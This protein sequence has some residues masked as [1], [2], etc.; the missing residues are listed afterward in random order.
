MKANNYR[1]HETID[2]ELASMETN[3][4]IIAKAYEYANRRELPALLELV[5]PCFTASQTDELPWGG[6]FHGH[7]GLLSFYARLGA[8]V[9]SA[10]TIDEIFEAGDRVVAIGR[11]KGTVTANGAAFDL[12]FVHVWRVHD[13]K[14]LSFNAYIDTPAMLAALAG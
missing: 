1:L 12:R 10:V 14:I 6:D 2:E 8:T 5:D 7:D 3:A 9:S 13:S 4:E 11:T